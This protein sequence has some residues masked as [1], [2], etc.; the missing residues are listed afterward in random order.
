M[1]YDPR[2]LDTNFIFIAWKPQTNHSGSSSIPQKYTT[3]AK[4]NLARLTG[5]SSQ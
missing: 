1:E 3:F 4:D 5:E 2:L